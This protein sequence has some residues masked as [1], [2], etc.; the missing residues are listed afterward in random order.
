MVPWLY[1][2]YAVNICYDF[3]L[4]HDVFWRY[5]TRGLIW[6][7][8]PYGPQFILGWNH[9]R[10]R[11]WNEPVLSNNGK[12]SY[13]MKQRGPLI[14]IEHTTSTLRGRRA[15]LAAACGRNGTHTISTSTCSKCNFHMLPP[16]HPN[17]TLN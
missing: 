6:H 8:C 17:K 13:S 12:M 2:V 4:V 1:G 9:T 7:L 3:K 5:L 11:S 14:G 16:P 10:I 15:T